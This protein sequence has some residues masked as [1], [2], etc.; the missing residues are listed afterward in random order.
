MQV[1]T[2]CHV[3]KKW[4]EE[5]IL[6][7]ITCVDNGTLSSE[8]RFFLKNTY[9][10]IPICGVHAPPFLASGEKY[11]RKE[12]L[13]RRHMNHYHVMSDEPNGSGWAKRH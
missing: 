7:A 12:I 13:H 3:K 11:D 10:Y 4:K 9:V 1:K 6:A 2:T 5:Q 8:Y